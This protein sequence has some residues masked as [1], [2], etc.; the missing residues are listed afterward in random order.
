MASFFVL[1]EQSV[2]LD[3]KLHVYLDKALMVYLQEKNTLKA[4]IFFSPGLSI[5]Q[6]VA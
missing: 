6:K 4:V 5:G 2:L 1:R 3:C